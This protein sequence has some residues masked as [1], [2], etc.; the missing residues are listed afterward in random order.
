MEILKNDYG[1]NGL[2]VR[3]ISLIMKCLTSVSYSMLVNGK[4]QAQFKPTR[5]L[6]KGDPLSPYL[7]LLYSEVLSCLIQQAEDQQML[8]GVP[9]ARGVVRISHLLS[10]YDNLLF[11]KSNPLEWRRL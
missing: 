9:I 11:I 4:P 6:R 10:T 8:H 1:E 2:S 7:F 3:W 5:G